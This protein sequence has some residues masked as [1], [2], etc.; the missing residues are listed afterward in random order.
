M[1]SSKVSSFS[2]VLLFWGFISFEPT[3]LLCFR[4]ILHSFV[5]CPTRTSIR[6]GVFAVGVCDFVTFFIS[7]N[8]SGNWFAIFYKW[9]II[10]T[11][12]SHWFIRGSRWDILNAFQVISCCSSRIGFSPFTDRKTLSLKWQYTKRAIKTSS[13][14]G[15]RY[16]MIDADQ[17]LHKS[18]VFIGDPF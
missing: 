5:N 9:M 14:K 8:A 3:I 12:S 15:S 16:L 6:V 4:R 17:N 18:Q 13:I 2:N 11:S 7:M 10:W 1:A